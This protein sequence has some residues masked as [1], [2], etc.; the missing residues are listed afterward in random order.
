[1]TAASNRSVSEML[2]L[3]QYCEHRDREIRI[4]SVITAIETILPLNLYPAH[5]RSLLDRCIWFVTEAD[6]KFK[7]RY[8]SIGA[9]GADASTKLQHEHVTEKRKLVSLL[10]SG[11]D[12][13]KNIVENAIGCVVTKDEHDLLTKVSRK[14]PSLDGWS[15]YKKAGVRVFDLK[16][17]KELQF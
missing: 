6:G 7:T 14:D 4:A 10:V 13:A 15:R 3:P 17:Q 8:R 5:K 2:E 11:E 9:L 16:L 12:D 1:M